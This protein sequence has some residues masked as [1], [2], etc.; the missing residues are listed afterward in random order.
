M[1][2]QTIESAAQGWVECRV[3]DFHLETHWEVLPGEV[4]VLFGPSGAGKS[5]TLRAVAGLLQPVKGHVEIGGKVVYDNEDGVWVPT[6][7]R[8]IGYLT[9]EYHL[10]PH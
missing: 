1:E 6:H 5:T 7:Q 10:F 3:G 4:L 2:S 8:R 9:Q